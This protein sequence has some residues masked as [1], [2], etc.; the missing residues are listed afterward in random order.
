M[1]GNRI[2]IADEEIQ[3]RSELMPSDVQFCEIVCHWLSITISIHW[4]TAQGCRALNSGPTC[5][6]CPRAASILASPVVRRLAGQRH[7]ARLRQFRRR[8]RLRYFLR[9]GLRPGIAA[10]GREAEPHEDL[11][12]VT[13]PPCPL[14]YIAPS[15][16]CAFGLPFPANERNSRIAA[17]IG[18]QFAR[19]RSGRRSQLGFAW[20]LPAS[21]LTGGFYQF[22]D[23]CAKGT[24]RRIG[25]GCLPEIGY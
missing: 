4:A 15:T 2:T 6:R 14:R 16:L 10:P 20:A 5:R 8:H 25:V 12:K 13:R 18:R 9:F 17:I 23:G 11:S 19:S 22:G 3:S 21:D 7:M 1:H 24:S